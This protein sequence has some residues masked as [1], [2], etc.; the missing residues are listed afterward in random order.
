MTKLLEEAFSK[1][2]KLPDG[3]QEALAAWIL[4]ELAAEKA[5]GKSLR[6]YPAALNQ[7]AEEALAEHRVGRTEPLHPSGE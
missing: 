1:L 2:S 3:E 7:L 4:E 5:W 6:E